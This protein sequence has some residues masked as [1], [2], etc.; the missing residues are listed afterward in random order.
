MR[1]TTGGIF[2]VIAVAA[3]VLLMVTTCRDCAPWQPEWN[4]GAA[5]MRGSQ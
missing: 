1:E 4:G 2:I 3:I 5:W